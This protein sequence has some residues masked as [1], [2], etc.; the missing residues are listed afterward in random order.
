MSVNVI[1]RSPAAGGTTKQSPSIGG[2]KRSGRAPVRTR[3]GADGRHD[4]TKEMS[5]R[6]S[7]LVVA[8]AVLAALA[9]P[10]YVTAA[11]QT[12]TLPSS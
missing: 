4:R 2:G 9:A 8:A 12:S 5:M 11:E 10:A 3:D 6:K 1:A 7:I